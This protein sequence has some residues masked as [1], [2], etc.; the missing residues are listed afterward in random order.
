MGR[1][2]VSGDEDGF[3]ILA[4]RVYLKP[5]SSA[6]NLSEKEMPKG[7]A[8]AIQEIGER[9]RWS[10]IAIPEPKNTTQYEQ[11]NNER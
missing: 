3:L 8:N 1:R 7:M 2:V 4:F 11:Q 5:L 6:V 9:T 10:S